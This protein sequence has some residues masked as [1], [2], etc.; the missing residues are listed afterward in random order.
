VGLA[1]PNDVRRV[2]ELPA[3]RRQGL[4]VERAECDTCH[5]TRRT[6]SV[7]EGSTKCAPCRTR[8]GATSSTRT[9]DGSTYHAGCWDR[10]VR[11]AA[12][13]ASASPPRTP[14]PEPPATG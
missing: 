14:R 4:T 13:R 2:I 3:D 1:D 6:L 11:D 8:I 7:L 12:K 9:V 5:T 10:K